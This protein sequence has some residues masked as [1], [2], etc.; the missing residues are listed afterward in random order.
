VFGRAAGNH[1]VDYLKEQRYHRS[2]P[3]QAV[4]PAF[5]RLARWD[6]PHGDER[7]EDLCDELRATMEKY[8]GVFRSREVLRE[9]LDRVVALHDRLQKAAIRDHSGRFNTARIEALELE[10]L[11]ELALATVASALVREE[12]RGAHWRFDFPERDDV[13]WLRHS[14]YYLEGRRVDSKPVRM[15]PL[16]VE[17]FPPKERVY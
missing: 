12:S 5:E 13:H 9:G 6:R 7:V 2:L 3:E 10:N 17:P 1:I 8:C 14:L 4:A 11:V 16:T 15:R